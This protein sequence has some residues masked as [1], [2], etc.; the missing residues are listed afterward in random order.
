[1]IQTGISATKIINYIKEHL[2]VILIV[3]AFIGGLW[4]SIELMSISIPYIRF[5]SIS[6]I[7]PDGI[8][9]LVLIFSIIIATEI[10]TFFRKYILPELNINTSN[11][12]LGPL[13]VQKKRQREIL[14]L[15]IQLFLVYSIAIYM[16][17]KSINGETRDLFDVFYKF[18]WAVFYITILNNYLHQLYNLATG[19]L[20]KYFK[21]FNLLLLVLYIII[22]ITVYNIIHKNFLITSELDNI[23]NIQSILKEKYPTSKR[24]ILYFNDKYI[25]INVT[26]TLKLDKVSKLPIEKVHIIELEKLFNE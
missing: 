16:F 23:E 20:K 9:I 12:E 13:E 3:P 1:M 24:E 25:F 14:N 8:L 2:N 19:K 6:Q 21:Y 10:G 22:L 18:I 17:I 15:L 11:K 5:F 4:Q 26:D 7:V